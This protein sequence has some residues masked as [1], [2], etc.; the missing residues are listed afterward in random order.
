MFEIQKTFTFEAG[1][2]L[3]HHDGH[4]RH[5]HGH[6]YVLTIH[7][8]SDRLITDGP[9]RNMVIDFGDISAC[10]SPMVDRYF[11][12]C[13]LNDTLETDS[14]TV[15]FMAQWIYNHLKPQLPALAAI[16]LHETATSKVTYRP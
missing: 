14:P 5:P 10:V 13:W 11:D 3:V 15:E 8:Q 4:C 7:L 2:S 9:K 6:S 16:T 12:H 1:H